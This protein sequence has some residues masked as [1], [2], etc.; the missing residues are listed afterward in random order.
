MNKLGTSPS[1]AMRILTLAASAGALLIAGAAIA[2]DITLAR[3]VKSGVE[4]RLAFSSSWDPHTCTATPSTVTI[5]RQPSHGTA[6]VVPG[7]Q[8]LPQATPGS[9]ATGCEGHKVDS[10]QVMYKSNPGFKGTDVVGY[11]NDHG[12]D[13]TITI[14]VE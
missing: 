14:T 2:K 12:I 10:H 5:S 6:S 3:T 9:G 7:V 11:H 13:A 4:T 1:S 8:T